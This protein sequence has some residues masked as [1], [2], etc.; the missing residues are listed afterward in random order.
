M[1]G[2]ERQT[3]CLMALHTVTLL[4]ACAFAALS[5]VVGCMGA[6][7]WEVRKGV[8]KCKKPP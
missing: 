4:S 2:R 7:V 6:V 3:S 1:S 8:G 5:A